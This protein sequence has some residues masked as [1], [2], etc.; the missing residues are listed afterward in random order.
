MPSVEV[1]GVRVPLTV[2]GHAGLELCNTRAG[3]GEPSP[4]EYLLSY[5]HLA[6]WTRY[7][8]LLPVV[9]KASAAQG[10]AVMRRLLDFRDA[11]YAALVGRNADWRTLAEETRRLGLGLAPVSDGLAPVSDQDAGV[12]RID[13]GDDAEAP[14]RAAVFAA[15][16]VLTAPMSRSVRACPGTGCGWVFHDPRGRR[17]WCTMA[18]CGNRAKAARHAA[19]LRSGRLA[20]SDQPPGSD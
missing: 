17:R 3:W 1:D 4:R 5:E 6:V 9:A 16:A 2:A 7:A 8:G 13:L 12:A 11:Y 19:L 20:G 15:V 18:I 14:L 10:A